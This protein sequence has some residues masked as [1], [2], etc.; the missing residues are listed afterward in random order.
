MVFYPAGPL[1][2]RTGVRSDLARVAELLGRTRS[3][4]LLCLAERPALS[5]HEL[6][7]AVGISPASASEHAAVLRRNH[8]VVTTR[9]GHRTVHTISPI[10]IQLID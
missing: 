7:T 3:R 6:A 2:A 10:G 8:L 9:V 1:L 5:T 4:I